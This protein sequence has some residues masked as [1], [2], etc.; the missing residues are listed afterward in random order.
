MKLR[1]ATRRSPLA[2]WQA[3]H[4]ADALTAL[5]AVSG[6]ELVECVTEG[7]RILDRSLAKVGGKGLFI[8]ELEQ[9]ML[10]D[11]ADLAVHS[12]KDVPA[13][14]PEAFVFPAFLER[15]DPRDALVGARLEQLA[16]GARVG[17]S[18]LRREAQLRHRRPDLAVAPVRGNVGTR[19][20]KLDSG[21]F[22]AIL[23]ATAGLKR[24]GLPERIAESL[25][26][27]TMLP[28]CGQG[29]V[30]IECRADASKVREVLAELDHATSRLVLGAE[31]EVAAALNADCHAPLGAHAVLEGEELWLRALVA[32]PDGSEIVAAEVRGEHT[33]TGH[34]HVVA[35]TLLS[36][37]AERWLGAAA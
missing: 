37:G 25:A 36:R 30:G 33:S 15:E 13:T 28:A 10:D 24:L 11:R 32:A 2:L 34:G 14:P 17:T 12:M 16:A 22:D 23:L 1:I 29:I 35:E 3:R 20:G 8:K 9:A 19:L 27:E 6:V 18:S 26:P 31:R 21:E 5:D 7:D 4:V